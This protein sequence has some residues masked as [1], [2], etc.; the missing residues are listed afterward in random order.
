MN[1]LPLHLYKSSIHCMAPIN[2]KE[3]TLQNI[4]IM[5]HINISPLP[6]LY[7]LPRLLFL[8]FMSSEPSSSSSIL[9]LLSLVWHPS[10]E[11]IN[12][13]Q[14]IIIMNHINISRLRHLCLLPL[15]N[16][17]L[18]TSHDVVV[19]DLLTDDVVIVQSFFTCLHCLYRILS[20]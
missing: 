15:L 5:N 3:K 18:R 13:L 19:S 10:S 12:I 9:N 7:L 16:L 20:A 4:I 14:T 11:K 2:W 17:E 6:H 8:I 1:L